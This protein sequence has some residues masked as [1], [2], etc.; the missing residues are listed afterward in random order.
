MDCR[1]TL[2]QNETFLD[3]LAQCRQAHEKV[4]MLLDAGGLSRAGGFIKNIHLEGPS[5]FLEM[6][7]GEKIEIANIIAVNG[8]FASGYSEC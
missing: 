4:A 5:P 6:E 3:M 1:I 8:V 7:N 2:R